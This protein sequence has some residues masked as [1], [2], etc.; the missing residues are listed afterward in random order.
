[1]SNR[2]STQDVITE[3]YV[4]LNV[5]A[6]DWEDAIKKS[7]KKLV[8]NKIIEARYVDA[9]IESIHKYGPYVVIGKGV[10]LAH[11]R[12]QDGVMKAGWNVITL[13]PPVT[14]HHEF[15]DPVRII[16]CLAAINDKAHLEMLS[17]IVKL[18]NS[19]TVIQ[20]LVEKSD[21]KDFIKTLF[22]LNS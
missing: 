11:A 17:T 18:I 10:A 16:F 14:F 1:M 19:E 12:P 5:E 2:N 6:Q 7:A 21:K 22:N 3:E 15:N 4:Q 13:N 9:M 20:E 8:D